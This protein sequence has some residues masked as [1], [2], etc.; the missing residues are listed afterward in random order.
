M[1]NITIFLVA[2]SLLIT[3]V[4]A[5]QSHKHHPLHDAIHSLKLTKEQFKRLHELCRPVSDTSDQL[6]NC[7]LG[8]GKIMERNYNKPETKQK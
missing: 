8:L 3:P 6:H 5:E 1:K 7:M 2:M 4:L